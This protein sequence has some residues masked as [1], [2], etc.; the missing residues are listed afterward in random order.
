MQQC[1][2][3]EAHVHRSNMFL[4]SSRLRASER[5]RVTWCT[6]CHIVTRNRV[7]YCYQELLSG[8]RPPFYTL[9]R[10]YTSAK[11]L[12]ISLY[13]FH[14]HLAARPKANRPQYSFVASGRTE[15]RAFQVTRCCKYHRN[16]A[17]CPATSR[18]KDRAPYA[19]GRTPVATRKALWGKEHLPSCFEG[20]SSKH[21][22]SFE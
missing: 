16:T 14:V 20:K 4:C 11:N 21:A 8:A 19:Q 6:S 7:H 18:W 3:L 10:A 13:G 5:W 17:Q 9:A 2:Q 12:I 22:P 15:T 1:V